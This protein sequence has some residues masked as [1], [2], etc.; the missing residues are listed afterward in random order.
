MTPAPEP[1]DLSTYR[2]RL[3]A[4]CPPAGGLAPVLARHLGL[5]PEDVSARLQAGTGVLCDCIEA[6]QARRLLPFLRAL[7]LSILAEAGDAG[8]LGLALLPRGTTPPDRLAAPVAAVL[9][10]AEDV[11]LRRL[12]RPGGLRLDGLTE[13]RCTGLK[14]RLA[15]IRGLALVTSHPETARYGLFRTRAAA[16]AAL[17]AD[18]RRLG[19]SRCA[20]TGA[21]AQDLD[22]PSGDW[23]LRRHPEAGLVLVDMAAQRFGL[24]LSGPAGPLPGELAD[25]LA[26]RL[27]LARTALTQRTGAAPLR[28]EAG[29][30]LPALR[31]FAADYAA[32][33]LPTVA[34]LAGLEP[35]T[36]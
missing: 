33:G 34:R 4:P 35:E 8:A 30:P 24:F 2:L 25:F 18:L 17:A 9:G 11:V 23:L 27:G 20:L 36:A 12:Q 32:I 15:P 16:D 31:Q 22:Q 10:L 14:A 6:G 21:L 7:G 28:L 13:P 19:L 26:P 1:S 29:L 3:S 5:C